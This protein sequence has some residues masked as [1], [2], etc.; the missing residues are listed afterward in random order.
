MT[1]PQY[2][3]RECT[4]DGRIVSLTKHQTELLS[5]LLMR[6]GQVVPHSD[7]IEA[8]YPDPDNS[9]GLEADAMKQHMVLLRFRIP[10]GIH[11]EFGVG[12]SIPAQGQ[13]PL[14]RAA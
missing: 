12:F 9:P 7:L 4:F 5:T 1:W 10:A 8:L 2:C 11:T 6:R 13:F 3:R 14:A